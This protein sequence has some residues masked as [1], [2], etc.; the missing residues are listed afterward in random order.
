[1]TTS[2]DMN[3]LEQPRKDTNINDDQQEYINNLQARLTQSQNGRRQ[4]R[5]YGRILRAYN[6]PAQWYKAIPVT[7]SIYF[8]DPQYQ[9]YLQQQSKLLTSNRVSI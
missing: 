1:M 6:T 8:Y 4:E 5:D 7:R 3:T 2:L 9:R